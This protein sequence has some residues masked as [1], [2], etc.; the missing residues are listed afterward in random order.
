MP[1]YEYECKACEL[2]HEVLQK[3]SDLPL[4]VCPHCGKPELKKKI[5][6][7]AFRL[8]GDGWYETDFKKSDTKKNLG[9]DATTL[10]QAESTDAKVTSSVTESSDTKASSGASEQSSTKSQSGTTDS[11]A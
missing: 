1:F 11:A 5:S 8:T 2:E 6:I 4:K 10:S 3:I 7:S 9:G